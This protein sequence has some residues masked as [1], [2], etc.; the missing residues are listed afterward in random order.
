MGKTAHGAKYPIGWENSFILRSFVIRMKIDML[1]GGGYSLIILN[2]L[3]ATPFAEVASFIKP[4]ISSSA[5]KF[6]DVRGP[7]L[8]NSCNVKINASLGSLLGPIILAVG[9]LLGSIIL[10]VWGLGIIVGRESDL[11]D[12]ILVI[13]QQQKSWPNA[14]ERKFTLHT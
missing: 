10:A 5:D 4:A 11:L 6:C 2:K 1:R 14:S 9:S 7:N 8:R 13:Y 3:E 12:P